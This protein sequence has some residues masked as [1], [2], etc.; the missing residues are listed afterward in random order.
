GAQVVGGVE[1]GVHV[2]EVRVRT[3][4]DAGRGGQPL[5]VAG[6][7]PAVLREPAPELELELQLR[8]VAAVEERFEEDGR[9]R[10]RRRLLVGEP[11]VARVPARLAR[12]RLEDVRVDLRQRMVARQLPEG[13]W[14]RRV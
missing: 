11:E 7:R 12:D 9:L 14:K 1:A 2:R 4:E 5:R 3:V 13:V 10:V 6:R 8:R